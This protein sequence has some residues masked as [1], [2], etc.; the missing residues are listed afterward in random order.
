MDEQHI[1]QL[2]EQRSEDAVREST[3]CW[4]ALLHSIAHRILGCSEDAEECCDDALLAAW[5]AIPPAKPTHLRAYLAALT[6]NL[7]L[8]RL[9]KENAEKRG[10][11]EVPLALEELSE[12]V[13]G[14]ESV[15]QAV[16]RHALAETIEDFVQ[17]LPGQQAKIFMR[18]YF[19]MMP[20]GEIAAELGVGESMVKSSLARAREKLRKHLE[21]EGFL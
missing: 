15:E 13:S 2:F 16:D 19:S 12:C 18:R 1:L 21:E 20:V 14:S 9:A 3:R 5:N 17:G 4:G 6:R 10:G 8:N 7:A 11:G